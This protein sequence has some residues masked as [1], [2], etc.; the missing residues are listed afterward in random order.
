MPG[1]YRFSVPSQRGRS[2]PWFSV[3]PVDV[4]TT[5]LVA[6]LCVLSFFVYAASPA[7]LE[8]LVQLPGRVRSGQIWRLITWPF[9]NVAS[10]TAAISIAIFWYLGSQIENILGRVKYLWLLALTTLVPALVGTLL[11]VPQAGIRAIELAIFVVFICE[12]PRAPFFFGI[13]A[14]VLGVVIVG[15]DLLQLIADRQT[16]VLVL[17]VVSMATAV[18]AARSFGMLTSLQWLPPIKLPFG[19]KSSR[20]KT[21]PS[22][23]RSSSGSGSVVVDGPWPT[24]PPMYSPMQDQAEVDHIL[25]KISQVGMDN[26]TEAEKKQLNEASRRLRKNKE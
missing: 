10:L 19:H 15:I 5:V 3:G 26:L 8:P 20:V 25:D 17:Y 2:D 22:R 18:W 24:S 23:S 4:T 9:A 13:P 16:E 1:R 21:A 7:A 11:D 14:W 12:Y 6:A